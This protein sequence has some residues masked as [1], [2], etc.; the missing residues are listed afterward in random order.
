MVSGQFVFNILT[1]FPIFRLRACLLYLCFAIS[2]L[3]GIF[4]F[5]ISFS[6]TRQGTNLSQNNLKDNIDKQLCLQMSNTQRTASPQRSQPDPGTIMP[7]HEIMIHFVLR[8]LIRQTRMRSHPEGLDVWFLIGPFVYFHTSCVRTAKALTRLRECAGSP[9]P[10]L[11]AYV[12]STIISGSFYFI[13]VHYSY[14]FL[15]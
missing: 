2:T 15:L 4:T 8:K 7:A 3:N 5:S 13:K 9:E 14:V 12:I 11:V 1:R 10:S 6:N